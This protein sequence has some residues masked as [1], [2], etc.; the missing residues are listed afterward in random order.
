MAGMKVYLTE[1][2]ELIMEPSLKWAGN[3]NVAVAVRAYGMKATIQVDGCFNFNRLSYHVYCIWILTEVFLDLF[4][5]YFV[6][7]SD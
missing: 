4:D 1:E 5:Y 3:P 6:Q 7:K 2:K